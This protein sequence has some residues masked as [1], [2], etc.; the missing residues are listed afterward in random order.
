MTD[1][2]KR[3]SCTVVSIVPF[4]ISEEKPGL[5]PNRY[6]IPASDG[7]EPVCLIVKEAKHN[8]YIDDTRGTLPVRDGSDEVARSIVQ[9][10]LDSQLGASDGCGPGLFWVVGA[11]TPEEIKKNFAAEL[12][13]ARISQQR[14]FIEICKLADNYWNR[15]HQH[16]VIND[17]QR[18][19]ADLLGYRKEDHEWM[20]P[21]EIL[22][23]IRCPACNISISP[24]LVVCTNCK[25]V[26]NPEKFKT[27][28]FATA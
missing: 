26:L 28:Q 20:A 13:A 12:S 9:D 15:H 4:S 27:L 11:W 10:F 19:A 5:I 7:K 17:F 8:V 6:N 14:W 2:E 22:K 23:A 3:L 24:E 16:N 25:C 18:K 21:S 1:S